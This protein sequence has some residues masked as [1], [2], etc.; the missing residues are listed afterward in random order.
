[1]LLATGGFLELAGAPSDMAE[2]N[3]ELVGRPYML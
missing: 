3:G 1:M 2:L